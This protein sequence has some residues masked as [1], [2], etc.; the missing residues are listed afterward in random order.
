[1]R[2]KPF[3]RTRRG[4][5]RSL[6]IAVV[7]LVAAGGV[8]AALPAA[9]V[10][11][12][13]KVYMCASGYGAGA[14]QSGWSSDAGKALDS[15]ANCS[16]PNGSIGKGDGLQ[17]WSATSGAGSEAGAYWLH[18]PTGT[19]ITGLTYAG[20]FSSWGGWVAHWATTEG[21]DGDPTSDCGTTADCNGGTIEEESFAVDNASLIG[22][23]VWCHASTCDQNDAYSLFGPGGSANVF[24]ATV[25]INEPNPPTLSFSHVSERVDQQ[26]EPPEQR[27]LDRERDGE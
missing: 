25:T 7:A 19:S 4:L 2:I 12:I 3:K 20:V 14:F 15:S 23:G 16:Q 10:A 13:Y 17:V 6:S 8:V 18:A 21:G 27:R 24:N 26:R 5:A 11:G 1:M 9:A 22:F